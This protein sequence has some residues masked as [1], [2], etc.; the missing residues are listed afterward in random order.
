VSATPWAERPQPLLDSGAFPLGHWRLATAAD[1]TSSR[2][3]L[4][5][6]VLTRAADDDEDALERLLLASRSWRRTG[7]GTAGRRSRCT[8]PPPSGAG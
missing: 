2:G 7:S 1:V 4:R 6:E 8:S 5:E 3:G